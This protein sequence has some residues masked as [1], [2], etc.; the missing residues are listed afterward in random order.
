MLPVKKIYLKITS[1]YI[2]CHKILEPIRKGVNTRY[3]KKFLIIR[4]KKTTSGRCFEIIDTILCYKIPSH[5]I[6]L[7]INLFNF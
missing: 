2:K 5:I 6:N 3:A 7:P 1:I 4:L